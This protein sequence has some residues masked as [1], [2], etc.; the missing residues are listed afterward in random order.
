VPEVGARAAASSPPLAPAI[1][2]GAAAA[3][4]LHLRAL[5]AW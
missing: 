3:M 4:L 5:V 2:V 1:A